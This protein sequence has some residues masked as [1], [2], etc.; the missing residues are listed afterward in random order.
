[1]SR[2]PFPAGSSIVTYAR[3]SGGE[4]QERSVDQQEAAYTEFAAAHQLVIVATFADRAKPGSSVV[5]R[6][7]FEAMMAY[8]HS[9]DPSSPD[10]PAGLLLWKVNR[11]ARNMDDS[12]FYKSDLRRRGYI[13]HF[14]ADDIPDVGPAA[15]L[16]EALKDYK[17][18]Q[19]L[20]D[21]S[22][23]SKRGLRSLVAAGYAP[24]RPPTCFIGQEIRS[25]TKR[26]GTPRKV[27][28]WIP[29]PA[30]WE[31]GRLAWAMRAAGASLQ[32]IHDATA[33]YKNKSSYPTFFA[34]EIYIG[35]FTYGGVRYEN[36]VPRLATQEQFDIVQAMREQSPPKKKS[37]PREAFS[38]NLISGIAYC[39]RCGTKLRG[40]SVKK[41]RYYICRRRE[42]SNATCDL[43]RI[44]ANRVERA[45]ITDVSDQI[46]SPASLTAML[47]QSITELQANKGKR[48]KEV[49]ATRRELTETS[50]AIT[51]LLRLAEIGGGQLESISSRL[52]EL[53]RR[54][55][56][57]ERQQTALQAN[58]SNMSLPSEGEL[59]EFAA[60]LRQGLATGDP[61]LVKPIL[62]ALIS[63]IDV[64]EN[65]A[66]IHYTF[67]MRSG[68]AN[69]LTMDIDGA[70][71]G[72]LPI[73]L[74]RWLSIPRTRHGPLPR[75]M[76]IVNG[77]CADPRQMTK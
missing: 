72:P 51:Q 75:P 28:K 53:E 46:L 60:R 58:L 47:A 48:N 38:R 50:K 63:R 42:G 62:R 34:N 16:I 40:D 59:R 37:H 18:E 52:G 61:H 39:A 1:M 3:D 64:D 43:P 70:P 29:D 14:L 31:R 21:I 71:M 32:A 8:M 44:S 27:S 74:V 2:N 65:G 13:L 33:L 26:N 69:G 23:D 73:S 5:G 22:T 12:Q 6:H 41:W 68:A 19:D 11:L 17:A 67:P 76:Q 24:G 10:R 15:R 54:K 4:E 30:T 9:T 25:G 77:A 45:V 20:T 49:Q 56:T 36:F 7:G 57:L 66:V 55:R 35:V